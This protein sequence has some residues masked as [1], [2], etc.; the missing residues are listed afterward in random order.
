MKYLKRLFVK[1]LRYNSIIYYKTLRDN[2]YKI[3][4]K[5]PNIDNYF[6]ID[7]SPQMQCPSINKIQNIINNSKLEKTEKYE[8]NNILEDLRSNIIGIRQWGFDWKKECLRIFI[9]NK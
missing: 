9:K 8:I 3:I 7:E 4:G 1:I 5:K 2:F 6:N